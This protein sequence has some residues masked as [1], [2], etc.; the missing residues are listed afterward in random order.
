MKKGITIELKTY[1][2]PVLFFGTLIGLNEV[3]TASLNLPYRSVFL[4][5]VS[6]ILLGLARYKVSKPFTS[7]MIVGIAILFKMNHTGFSSCNTNFLLCGPAALLFIGVSY[8]IFSGIFLK[9]YNQHLF[10]FAAV[11]VLTALTGFALFAFMN[12]YLLESWSADRMV[13][14][15][16]SRGAMTALASGI[17]TLAGLSLSGLSQ[18]GHV[19]K[20]T[21]IS[22]FYSIFIILLWVLGTFKV[23]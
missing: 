19:S 7:L 11:A 17:I 18:K 23:I 1:V 5:S 6:I 15:I 21:A 13:Q 8:E 2:L 20:P 3:V 22:G 9:K 12:T 4:N 10:R 16:F 14:Y